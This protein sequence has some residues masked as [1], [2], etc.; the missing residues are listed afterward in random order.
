MDVTG[1]VRR[2][3]EIFPD[4][5]KV[6]LEK[7]GRIVGKRDGGNERGVADDDERL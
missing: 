6:K 1:N 7:T 3:R 4:V 5:G 2:M